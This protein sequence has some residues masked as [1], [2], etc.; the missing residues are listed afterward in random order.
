MEVSNTSE[1]MVITFID[2]WISSTLIR[3]RYRIIYAFTQN[4]VNLNLYQEIEV[5]FNV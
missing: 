5:I 1:N 2:T 3:R 4:L